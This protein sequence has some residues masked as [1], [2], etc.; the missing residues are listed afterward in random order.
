MT[1]ANKT[2]IMINIVAIM[3]V[4][5]KTTITINMAATTTATRHSLNMMKA[6]QNTPRI[7]HQALKLRA[8]SMWGGVDEQI[9]CIEASVLLPFAQRQ[10]IQTNFCEMIKIKD[11][12]AHLD[13]GTI[14]NTR[15][16]DVGG[17][18]TRELCVTSKSQ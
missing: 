4:A 2:T 5:H 14:L 11:S 1:V 8:I 10:D 16:A 3:T 15:I 12:N 17:S 9:E 18:D 6:D 7:A 13:V